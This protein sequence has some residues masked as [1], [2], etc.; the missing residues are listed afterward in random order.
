[1]I[2]LVRRKISS[3]KPPIQVSSNTIDQEVTLAPKIYPPHE[4]TS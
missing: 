2:F 3:L 4:G 1:M